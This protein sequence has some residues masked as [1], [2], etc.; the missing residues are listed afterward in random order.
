MQI[1]TQK[2]HLAFS[3]ERKHVLTWSRDRCL[4]RTS[5][6]FHRIFLRN[7]HTHTHTPNTHRHRDPTKW[8]SKV[9]KSTVLHAPLTKLSEM[10]FNFNKSQRFIRFTPT[11]KK[12]TKDE[13]TAPS[14]LTTGKR[15]QLDG[16]RA[17]CYHWDAWRSAPV[18]SSGRS[19]NHVMG[20]TPT[21]CHAFDVN[22]W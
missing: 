4:I 8:A 10:S 21:I 12:K 19:A 20:S 3:L 6:A 16:E 15:L 18:P 7:T 14:P 13:R 9:D 1:T 5:T 17:G 22:S 2:I 11:L